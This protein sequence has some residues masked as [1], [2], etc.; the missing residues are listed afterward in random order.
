MPILKTSCHVV[1]RVPAKGSVCGLNNP[2]YPT[3][4]H[5][6]SSLEE[7]SFHRASVSEN[8]LS[9][10]A[11]STPWWGLCFDP[12]APHSHHI[13]NSFSSFFSKAVLQFSYHGLSISL[14]ET[15]HIACPWIA[16][17]FRSLQLTLPS[18]MC[19]S[20]FSVVFLP[21]GKTHSFLLNLFFFY[22]GFFFSSLCASPVAFIFAVLL[23]SGIF[24]YFINSVKPST[25]HGHQ[26]ISILVIKANFSPD[27]QADEGQTNVAFNK[28]A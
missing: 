20:L 1:T 8:A 3:R 5:F 23:A 18:S 9:A 15:Q 12:P 7:T 17:C 22:I 13:D 24:F 14:L 27:R 21:T 26:S 11:L 19:L 6:L 2:F 16:H 10:G 4:V 28:A 25:L